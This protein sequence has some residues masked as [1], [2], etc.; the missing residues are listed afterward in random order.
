MVT[1]PISRYTLN[2]A[3]DSFESS[4]GADMEERRSYLLE[5]LRQFK[6]LAAEVPA[7]AAHL[8]KWVAA[9]TRTGDFLGRGQPSFGR[10]RAA[11]SVH[12]AL[13]RGPTT[14][15]STK[16]LLPPTCDDQMTW[17]MA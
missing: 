11:T 12:Q 2:P 4:S 15:K 7:S 16:Q 9:G 17:G 10:C 13:E 8:R 6:Q 3:A 1:S 5:Q 14:R